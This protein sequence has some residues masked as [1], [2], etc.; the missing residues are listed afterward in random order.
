VPRLR[1]L[2][3]GA[4]LRRRDHGTDDFDEEFARVASFLGAAALAYRELGY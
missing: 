3:G 2:A 1:D 4:Q